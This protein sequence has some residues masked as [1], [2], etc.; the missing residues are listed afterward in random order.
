MYMCVCAFMCVC[1]CVCACTHNESIQ[2]GFYQ[3]NY[4][5]VHLCRKKGTLPILAATGQ[6]LHFIWGGTTHM[7]LGLSLCSS[8]SSQA[9]T[10]LRFLGA[11]SLSCLG[12]TIQKQSSQAFGSSSLSVPSSVIFLESQ[13]QGFQYRSVGWGWVPHSHS[14]MQLDQLRVSVIVPICSVKDWGE[15]HLPCWHKNGTLEQLDNYIGTGNWQ[16]QVLSSGLWPLQHG[17]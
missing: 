8:L 2:H 17:Q 7:S 14:A 15:L 13:V 16:Q 11:F 5:Y 1:V 10:V 3:T 9:T 6:M 4:L 12:D